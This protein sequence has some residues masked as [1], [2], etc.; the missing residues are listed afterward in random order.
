MAAMAVDVEISLCTFTGCY[1]FIRHRLY[2]ILCCLDG[3]LYPINGSE[4]IVWCV[5]SCGNLI[6]FK[7]VC[8]GGTLSLPWNWDAYAWH[9]EA[10][11]GN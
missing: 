6:E 4:V 7:R 9:G 1:D 8:G 11:L 5:L 3:Q 10:C 2:R